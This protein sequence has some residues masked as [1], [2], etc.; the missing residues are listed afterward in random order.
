MLQTRQ[1]D[2]MVIKDFLKI[3][4]LVLFVGGV[5]FLCLLQRV[6]SRDLDFEIDQLNAR[7]AGLIKEINQLDYRI[8]QLKM[9]ERIIPLAKDKLGMH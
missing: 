8:E 2:R 7:R 9:P 4:L 1:E 5:S 3:L 6:R